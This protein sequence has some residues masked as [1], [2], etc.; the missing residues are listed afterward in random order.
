MNTCAKLHAFINN[1]Q[2]IVI[3]L[4][5]R[6]PAFLRPVEVNVVSIS[7]KCKEEKEE[8]HNGSLPA[9]ILSQNPSP[10]SVSTYISSKSLSVQPSTSNLKN[11]SA[12]SQPKSND[13]PSLNQYDGDISD[14]RS[15]MSSDISPASIRSVP[16][17]PSSLADADDVCCVLDKSH[18]FSRQLGNLSVSYCSSNYTWLHSTPR[19]VRFRFPIVLLANLRGGLCTKLDELSVVLRNNCVDIAVLTIDVINVFYV[20]YSGHVFYVF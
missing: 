10:Q 8:T 5:N 12:L 19:V 20:F 3:R 13:N 9:V 16:S 4:K 18:D 6:S 14:L 15:S 7:T 17:I 1:N 2:L 11:E